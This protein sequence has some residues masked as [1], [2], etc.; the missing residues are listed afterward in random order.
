MVVSHDER[1]IRQTDCVLYEVDGRRHTV[2]RFDGDFDDYREHVL[3]TLGETV[4]ERAAS[5][6]EDS[7]ED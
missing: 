5:D 2:R 3:S 1:L 4:A 7:D 6:A